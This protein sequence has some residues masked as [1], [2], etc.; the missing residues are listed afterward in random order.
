MSNWSSRFHGSRR[1]SSSQQPGIIEPQQQPSALIALQGQA[2]SG[3]ASPG[4]PKKAPT[5]PRDGRGALQ[6]CSWAVAVSLHSGIFLKW[7]GTTSKAV[8]EVA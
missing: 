6:Q 2:F 3:Q 4:Q 7:N 8:A 5:T 1:A